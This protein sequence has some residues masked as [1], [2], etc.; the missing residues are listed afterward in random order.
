MVQRY[1]EYGNPLNDTASATYGWL[2]GY[3]RSS[4]TISGL[5]LM[6]SRLYS[7]A[8]GRF[9][10]TDA[11]YG[12]NVNAYVYPPDPVNAYDLD[13]RFVIVIPVV[14]A[15]DWAL[16]ALIALIVAT[17]SVWICHVFGCSLTASGTGVRVPWPDKNSKKS[18]KEKN[19]RYY[20]YK[21]YRKNGGRIYKYGITKVGGS[22]PRSQI[23]SCQRYYNKACGYKLI[24]RG[25]GWYNAR[26]WEATKILKYVAHHG[27]CPPGQ[28][29]SCR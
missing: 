10:Q 15:L 7:P 25:K 23:R 26:V 11:V 3:Q 24:W 19:T 1:D 6:G 29:K 13:G 16:G 20:G 14:I 5:A 2:G 18:K 28:Y 8:T 12:G 27:H 21:I 9:L 17:V 22:R 4:D